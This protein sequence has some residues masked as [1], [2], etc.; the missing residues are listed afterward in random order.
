MNGAAGTQ[1]TIYMQT[2]PNQI[3]F[4]VELNIC[5]QHNTQTPRHIDKQLQNIVFTFVSDHITAFIAKKKNCTKFCVWILF[6][7]LFIKTNNF[8]FTT[9]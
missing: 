6:T 2:M 5:T 9:T 7:K 8:I 1:Y 3:L 4:R